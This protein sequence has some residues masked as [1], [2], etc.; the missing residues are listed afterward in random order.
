MPS[1]YCKADY[2]RSQQWPIELWPFSPNMSM[3]TIY[4]EDMPWP[5]MGSTFN[6]M[7][8]GSSR[9]K[10]ASDTTPLENGLKPGNTM[11]E[12][13]LKSAKAS[14]NH[15][16]KPRKPAAKRDSMLKSSSTGDLLQNWPAR[17]ETAE[18]RG[19]LIS[20][21][22]LAF[23]KTARAF[24][25]ERGL[26]IPQEQD[27]FL[28][29]ILSQPGTVAVNDT[30]FSKSQSAACLR[31]SS[32]SEGRGSKA[33]SST[34]SRSSAELKMHMENMV[35]HELET[36]VKPLKRELHGEIEKRKSAEALGR[37]A[38][39]PPLTPPRSGT[40]LAP[41]LTPPKKRV[42]DK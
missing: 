42:H 33:T 17:G 22:R 8:N 25:D 12:K 6:T 31:G 36:V 18:Q 3:T 26:K 2:E 15:S 1:A 24:Y 11:K 41:L 32:K 16:S 30:C 5:D 19:N 10:I 39:L 14:W 38:G 35:Q 34:R 27:E 7:S 4:R 29:R 28:K 37:A 23:A 13:S 21:Q 40:K 9:L 20:K